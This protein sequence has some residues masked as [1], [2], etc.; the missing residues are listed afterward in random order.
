MVHEK[1]DPYAHFIPQ[2]RTLVKFSNIYTKSCLE[3][4]FIHTLFGHVVSEK[5][6]NMSVLYIHLWFQFYRLHLPLPFAVPNIC[7][8]SV[9]HGT[10]TSYSLHLNIQFQGLPIHFYLLY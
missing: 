6:L 10:N 1:H 3:N 7:I 4:P 8:P 2:G 5:S 9:V